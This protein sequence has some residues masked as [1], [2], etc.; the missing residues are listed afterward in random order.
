MTFSLGLSWVDK[1]YAMPLFWNSIPGVSVDLTDLLNG[2][3]SI[4]MF[5]PQLMFPDAQDVDVQIQVSF[6]DDTCM[7][8][9]IKKEEITVC[10]CLLLEYCINPKEYLLGQ[11]CLYSYLSST[12]IS[13]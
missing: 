1:R 9:S 5:M 13:I 11:I 6:Y 8:C 2:D 4:N 10:L 12:W 3:D 7:Q